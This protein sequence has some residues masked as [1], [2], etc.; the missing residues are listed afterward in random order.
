MEKCFIQ[1]LFPRQCI[2]HII[3]KDLSETHWT[4]TTHSSQNKEHVLV[5]RTHIYMLSNVVKLKGVSNKNHS[6]MH[7]LYIMHFQNMNEIPS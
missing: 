6:N 7:V 2:D 3:S 1:H 4:N 5:L